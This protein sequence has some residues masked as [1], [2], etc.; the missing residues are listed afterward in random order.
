MHG[1]HLETETHPLAPLS[2]QPIDEEM[3]NSFDRDTV[4]LNDNPQPSTPENRNSS[5]RVNAEAAD[6][7]NLPSTKIKKNVINTPVS[8]LKNNWTAQR[9]KESRSKTQNRVTEGKSKF[10]NFLD[11]N[12]F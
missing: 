4:E 11:K 1:H 9:K 10:S 5:A 7:E 2:T 12:K 8:L 3:M 6:G